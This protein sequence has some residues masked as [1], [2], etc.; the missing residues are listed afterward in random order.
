M[1]AIRIGSLKL[2]A[3]GFDEAVALVRDRLDGLATAPACFG[4]LNPHVYNHGMADREV[5]EFIER[6]EAVCLDGVGVA[7]AGSLLNRSFLPRAVMHQVFDACIGAGL[8]RGRV[9][10][11]GLTP[12]DSVRACE[13]LRLAAP[14]AD[15]V[16]CRH[17]FLADGDYADLFHEYRDADVILAGMGT[18]RSEHVLLMASRICRHALCWHVGGGSLR[19]W[20]GT[21]RRAPALVSRLG[22][23]WLHRMAHEPQTRARYVEGVPSFIRHLL[24]DALQRRGPRTPA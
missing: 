16:A 24:A 10:M 6:C 7:L 21:K 18:P 4:F 2:E 3:S 17:G 22:L 5:A 8:L 1:H 12:E 13:S 14:L 9:V 15:F 23:E 11:I 20:A 19:H